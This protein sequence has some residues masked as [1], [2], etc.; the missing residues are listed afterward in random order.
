LGLVADA[1][2]GLSADILGIGNR[3]GLNNGNIAFML[4]NVPQFER[5]EPNL[6]ISGFA[7]QYDQLH[8]FRQPVDYGVHF[9]LK[10]KVNC[11]K[12]LICSPQKCQ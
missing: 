2:S 5:Q 7:Y 4:L 9:I 11:A 1:F 3:K 8:R 6:G 12:L 10:K